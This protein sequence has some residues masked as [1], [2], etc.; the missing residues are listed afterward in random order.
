MQIEEFT[1]LFKDLYLHIVYHELDL[2]I[3]F[4][5]ESID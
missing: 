4:N 2:P 1:N 3:V 5:F